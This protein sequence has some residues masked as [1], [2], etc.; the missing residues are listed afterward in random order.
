MVLLP[1]VLLLH[2]Q[3]ASAGPSLPQDA[4]HDASHDDR[5]EAPP[6][7]TIEQKRPRKTRVWLGVE[8]GWDEN[9]RLI[10]PME[11]LPDQRSASAFGGLH[12]GGE[13]VTRGNGL[14]AGGDFEVRRF[15]QTG[16]GV[17]GAASARAGWRFLPTLIPD[18]PGALRLDAVLVGTAFAWSAFPGDRH[19]SLAFAPEIAARR[20]RLSL[21]IA[22]TILV[23]SFVDGT[24]KE[25]WVSAVGAVR[26]G[27]V[28]LGA[29]YLGGTVDSTATVLTR[30]LHRADAFLSVSP[31]PTLS[32]T[33]RGSLT[34]KTL[35]HF[36]R[37]DVEMTP[38]REDRLASARLLTRWGVHPSLSIIA[39]GEL[40]SND[41]TN[42]LARHTRAL[43]SLGLEWHWQGAPGAPRPDAPRL[44]TVQVEAPAAEKVE[45]AGS[46]NDW[47]PKPL[48]RLSNGGR[49][50]LTLPIPPGNHRFGFLLDGQW[51]VPSGVPLGDD[52]FGGKDA[53]LV[54]DAD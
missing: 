18:A 31:H 5:H 38:G 36:P 12:G 7:A 29:G 17:L 49:W 13:L 10:A 40:L 21:R 3:V 44:V 6:R 9:V 19:L 2:T 28:D 1:V 33:L 42:A 45:L 52:G 14:L 35:P 32:L 37:H 34:A 22:P 47:D 43:A 11:T 39:E 48:N 15:L 26:L 23:R 20:G 50:G 16:N 41:S 27:I 25:A 51:T 30:T 8:S 54:V 53:V 46:F 4:S 24:D